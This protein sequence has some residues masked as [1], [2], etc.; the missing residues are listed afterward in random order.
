MENV[1]DDNRLKYAPKHP[2]ENPIEGE[3][4]RKYPIDNPFV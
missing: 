4:V 3:I 2:T 1:I